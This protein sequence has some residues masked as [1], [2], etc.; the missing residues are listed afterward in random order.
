MGQQQLLLLVLSVIIVGIA[1]VVGIQMFSTSAE[2]ANIE[3]VTNDL[4]HFASLAQQYYIKPTSMGGGGD[5]FAGISLKT[6]VPSATGSSYSNENGSYTCTAGTTSATLTG[7]PK[8]GSNVVTVTV[9]KDHVTT[10]I[11][12]GS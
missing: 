10:T 7:T 5:S 6:L 3:A 12:A 2:S 9:Y 11:A 4:V 1:V 8:R